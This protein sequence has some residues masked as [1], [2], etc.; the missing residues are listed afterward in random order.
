MKFFVFLLLL[1]C[2]GCEVQPNLP[3]ELQSVDWKVWAAI[4]VALFVSPGKILGTVTEQLKRIP[5]GEQAM[6]MLGLIKS[7]D[8]SP[9]KLTDSEAAEA[10]MSI[11]LKMPAGLIRDQL[12]AAI[13]LAMKSDTPSGK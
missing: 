13:T 10:M 9:G 4:A 11:A 12:I 7:A 3:P 6:R 8:T 1:C 2:T 5:F